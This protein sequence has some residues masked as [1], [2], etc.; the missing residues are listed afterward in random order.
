MFNVSL[1]DESIK[2]NTILEKLS[3]EENDL[4]HQTVLSSMHHMALINNIIHL[5][6][7]V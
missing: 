5:M 6:N 2:L 4:I 7:E 3:L 1:C